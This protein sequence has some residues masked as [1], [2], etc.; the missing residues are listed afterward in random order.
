MN[1]ELTHDPLSSAKLLIYFTMEFSY[2]CV[3]MHN[4]YHLSFTPTLV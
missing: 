4:T 1:L 2:M 3:I